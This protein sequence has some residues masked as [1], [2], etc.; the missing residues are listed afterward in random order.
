MVPSLGSLLCLSL[1]K[2]EV[3]P[4]QSVD[5]KSAFAQTE[6]DGGIRITSCVETHVSH[7]V[8]FAPHEQ[9]TA[10]RVAHSWP[11]VLARRTALVGAGLCVCPRF[12]DHPWGAAANRAV[13]SSRRCP[14]RPSRGRTRSLA[15]AHRPS[16]GPV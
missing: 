9:K 8:P 14:C 13:C 4:R 15:P 12:S 10:A 2:G 5:P 16:P 1:S 6:P 11:A 7:G 3:V